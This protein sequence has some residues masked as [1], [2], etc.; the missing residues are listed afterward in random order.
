VVRT[1][2]SVSGCRQGSA[3]QL[4]ALAHPLQAVAAARGGQPSRSGGAVDR[5]LGAGIGGGAVLGHQRLDPRRRGHRFA[6][7]H[8]G[9]VARLP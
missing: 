5:Q 9:G 4:R 3:E 8:A 2:I 7:Q 1:T 6:P